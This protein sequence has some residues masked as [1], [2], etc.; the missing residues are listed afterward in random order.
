MKIIVN[1]SKFEIM[2]KL[3]VFKDSDLGLNPMVD[4]GFE[5][6]V[7]DLITTVTVGSG[8]G[9]SRVDVPKTVEAEEYC[10]VFTKV[11]YRKHV[12]SLS[13]KA[14]ELFLWL[15]YEVDTA[16]EYACINSD[17]YKAEA[18]VS[19]NTYRAALKELIKAV[20]IAPTVIQTV[21]WINPR[22]FFNGSRVNKYPDNLVK[23]K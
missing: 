10:K 18:G 7:R 8:Y 3:P 20:V 13:S 21:Y 11:A 16:K 14:K 6:K 1:C 5:I 12:M 22:L 15:I 19:D 2:Y 4:A 23:I 17:R 9:S